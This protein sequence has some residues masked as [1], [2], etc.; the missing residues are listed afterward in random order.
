MTYLS[1]IFSYIYNF[2]FFSTIFIDNFSIIPFNSATIR[3]EGCF[4]KNN[5][6]SFN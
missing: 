5:I 1:F 4:I 3:I 6:F 2:E